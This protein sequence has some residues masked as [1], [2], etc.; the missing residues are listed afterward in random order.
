M[1]KKIIQFIPYYGIYY[2]NKHKASW[3]NG[4]EWGDHLYF[5]TSAF[6]QAM[7]IFVPCIVLIFKYFL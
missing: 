4:S 3:Y 6:A 5:F 7:F 1:K 2:A